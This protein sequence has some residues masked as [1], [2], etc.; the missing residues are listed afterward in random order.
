VRRKGRERRKRRR[1]RGKDRKEGE[2]GIE[3]I[4]KAVLLS[5]PTIP[6]EITIYS[7]PILFWT[8][9]WS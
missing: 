9:I 3:G 2:K 7:N 5:I 1:G 8:P 6:E 4:Q